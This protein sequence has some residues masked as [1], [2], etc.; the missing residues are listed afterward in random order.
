MTTT[1]SEGNE[2]FNAGE[3]TDALKAEGL[4]SE[5]WH[6][7]GGCATIYIRLDRKCEEGD[8]YFMIGPGSYHWEDPRKSLFTTDEL[9]YGEDGNIHANP[10]DW[11]VKPGTSIP[12]AAKEIAQRFREV[13]ETGYAH[14]PTAELPKIKE[15]LLTVVPQDGSH[16][17]GLRE[18]IALLDA[19]MAKRAAL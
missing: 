18:D 16:A 2:Y 5:I 14:V 7:G 9:Y 8:D 3:L 1:E 6:T 13:N 4:E 15:H 11:T 17:K 12:D 19:E 10:Q